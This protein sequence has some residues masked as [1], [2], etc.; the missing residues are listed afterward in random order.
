MFSLLCDTDCGRRNE[1]GS[2]QFLCVCL[3]WR[4]ER[5]RKGHA[6]LG[7][8]AEGGSGTIGRA[9]YSKVIKAD[10]AIRRPLA[11]DCFLWPWKKLHSSEPREEES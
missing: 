4:Q 2:R 3:R 5:W 11:L 8:M 7:Q 9:S 1:K 10:L 6:W